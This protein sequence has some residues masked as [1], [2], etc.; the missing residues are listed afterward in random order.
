MNL[1]RP[2][3]PE[4]VRTRFSETE[5]MVFVSQNLVRAGRNHHGVALN[6]ALNGVCEAERHLNPMALVFGGAVL[7]P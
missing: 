7:W 2:Q 6:L 4:L 5:W 1:V 3:C